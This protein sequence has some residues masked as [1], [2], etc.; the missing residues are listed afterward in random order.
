[1][2]M[3]LSQRPRLDET[4]ISEQAPLVRA[5]L[6]LR[7]QTLWDAVLPGIRN[8]E[9]SPDW[10]ADPR[11]V[12]AGVRVLRNLSQ[13]YRLDVGATQEAPDPAGTAAGIRELVSAQLDV[14]AARSQGEE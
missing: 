5:E 3:D 12:E 1:M 4:A 2:D 10:R 7:Y 8:L 11:M 14:L 13:L 6:A 9:D